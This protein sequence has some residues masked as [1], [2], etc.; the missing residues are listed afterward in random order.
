MAKSLSTTFEEV[1]N[2]KLTIGQ[3]SYFEE[4]ANKKVM[5][6]Q[7][8]YYSLV[9]KKD[10]IPGVKIVYFIRGSRTET[11][12]RRYQQAILVSFKRYMALLNQIL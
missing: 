10:N 12:S 11:K 5:I 1:A 6:G 4:V 2:R 9:S 3:A 8:S 7:A